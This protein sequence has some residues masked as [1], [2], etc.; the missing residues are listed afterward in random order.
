MIGAGT[1]GGRNIAAITKSRSIFRRNTATRSGAIGG[2]YRT[3]NPN[4]RKGNANSCGKNM[5]GRGIRGNIGGTTGG[6]MTIG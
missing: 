5:R 6:S 2:I 4:G 3:R 1:V